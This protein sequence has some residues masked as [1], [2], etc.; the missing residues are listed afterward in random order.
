[1]GFSFDSDFG[2]KL[3]AYLTDVPDEPESKFKCDRCGLEFFPDDIYFNIEGDRLCEN[4]A[5]EWLSE[6]GSSATYDQCFYAD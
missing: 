4:C 3:D 2:H 5:N 1:M 6:Q